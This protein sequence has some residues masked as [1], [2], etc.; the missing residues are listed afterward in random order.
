L[1]K[2]AQANVDRA[3]SVKNAVDLAVIAAIGEIPEWV[4]NPTLTCLTCE[5]AI[6]LESLHEH[7]GHRVWHNDHVHE[8]SGCL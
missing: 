8:C 3:T 4:Y 6:D 5:K 1:F 7:V 2:I